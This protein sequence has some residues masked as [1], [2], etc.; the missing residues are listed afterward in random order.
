MKVRE[1][2]DLYDNWNGST[3]IN[4]DDLK[5]IWIGKTSTIGFNDKKDKKLNHIKDLEVVSF[6]F[7]GDLLTIRVK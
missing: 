6:G 4:N 7:Y 3:K 1:F 5:C 2:L